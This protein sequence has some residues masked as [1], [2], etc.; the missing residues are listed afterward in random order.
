LLAGGQAFSGVRYR[1]SEKAISR[2]TGELK[3]SVSVKGD[4][5]QH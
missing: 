4:L 5:R 3:T 2:E 1:A